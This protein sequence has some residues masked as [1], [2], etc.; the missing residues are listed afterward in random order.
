MLVSPSRN[1]VRD[2]LYEHQIEHHQLNVKK[3]SLQAALK[4]HT[5]GAQRFKMAFIK[6]KISKANLKKRVDY[7]HEHLGKTI[8]DFWRFIFF[9]DESHIDPSS[10]SQGHVL[11][12]VGTRYDA[13]N[14]QE[15][16]EKKGVKLHVA[17]WANW[18]F[19]AS[20]LEFYN[21]ENDSIIKPKRPAKPRKSRYES[22]K[23]FSIRMLQWEADLPHEAEVKPKRNGM[24]QKYYC[25]RLLPLYIEA[26][27]EASQDSPQNWLFQEDGDPSHGIRKAGLAQHIKNINGIANLVYPP[28]SPDLNPMEGV[29]NILKQR[30][31]RRRWTTLDKLKEVLQDE[32]SKITMQEVRARIAEMPRRCQL[33]VE[34]GG[35]PIKSELW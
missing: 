6:K 31:R 4:K 21:D 22:D 15:R 32:W 1:P 7:G 20:K 17:A 14:I 9:S 33:F 34:T 27:Q 35:K 28:Q 18:Y 24:T 12:E 23:E 26:I 16:G 19:K 11:R 13:V 25:E 5:K 30:I 10:M 2:Q 3:R 8:Y 29:W